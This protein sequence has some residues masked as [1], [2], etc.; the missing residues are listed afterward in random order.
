MDHKSA[1][2]SS[3]IFG[4]SHVTYLNT[5]EEQT[6]IN[7]HLLMYLHL[8]YHIMETYVNAMKTSLN[9]LGQHIAETTC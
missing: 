1:I 8:Q 6:K 7:V 5:Y 9:Y 3:K 2:S 4:N